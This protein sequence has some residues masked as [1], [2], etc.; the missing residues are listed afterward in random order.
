MAI[1][2]SGAHRAVVDVSDS[3]KKTSFRMVTFNFASLSDILIRRNSRTRVERLITRQIGSDLKG[4]NP[5]GLAGWGGSA[6]SERECVF[7]AT[8]TARL[9]ENDVHQTECFIA[10]AI[11]LPVRK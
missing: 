2:V 10:L 9:P 3:S 1:S 4:R 5:N 8:I 7:P 11:T 6:Q